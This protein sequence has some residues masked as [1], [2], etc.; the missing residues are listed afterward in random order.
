MSKYFLLVVVLLLASC[1]PKS[2]SAEFSQHR[3]HPYLHLW[4]RKTLLLLRF[5]KSKLEWSS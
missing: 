5:M 3:P 4:I 2:A 1:A